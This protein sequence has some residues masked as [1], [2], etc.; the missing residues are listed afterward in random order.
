MQ[1]THLRGQSR[2]LT[3]ICARIFP[4]C[5]IEPV[6]LDGN[7]IRCEMTTPTQIPAFE[8]HTVSAHPNPSAGDHDDVSILDLLITLS[9]Q[10]RLV[11][12]M[13]VVFCVLSIIIAFLLPKRY[14]ATVLL[15]PPQQSNSLGAQLTSQ[16]G[17]LSG[18]ALAAS[19]AGGLLK[20]TNDMY[21]SMLKSRTVEDAMIDRFHLMEEYKKRYISDARKKFE[22]RTSVDGASKDGLIRISVEDSD[23]K[24]AAEL[25]NGYVDQFRNLSEHLAISE[26]S[27]RRAFF[28]QQMQRAKENLA[29]A[30]IALTQTQQK[31]GL[32]QLDSQARALIE[33]AAALRAQIT[34]KEVQIQGMRSYATPENAQ[35]IQAQHE[36]DSMHEQLARLGGSGDV[37]GSGIIPGRGQ[38][39]ASGME[40]VR[41]LRDLKYSETIFEILARQFEVAKLDEAREGAVIQVVDPAVP[42]DKRS[43]PKRVWI[44]AGGT[45]LGLLFGVIAA[46]FA[47]GL[48]SARGSSEF[49]DKLAKLRRSFSWNS[50][51]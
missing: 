1:V 49:E 18:M 41:R 47:S 11:I 40:Y 12:N 15:L 37:P 7:L 28:E 13:T 32:I 34:A 24:R 4:P 25:A 19:G 27:Q 9:A 45:L 16:L 29:N 2:D 20:N 22:S 10:K 44:I 23:P 26:A 8:Q 35:L 39:T 14:T 21:V 48:E 51:P 43:F 46:F 38:M 33:S 5:R 17:S 6:S 50:R 30:E 3:S 42:P 36:L 31:T